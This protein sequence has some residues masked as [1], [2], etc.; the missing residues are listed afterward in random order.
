VARGWLAGPAWL[1][2]R[3]T[4]SSL[5]FITFVFNFLV[6]VLVI[7]IDPNEILKI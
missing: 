1:A 3:S 5:F 6:L 4:F 7:Q 2:A